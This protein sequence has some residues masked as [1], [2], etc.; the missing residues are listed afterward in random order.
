MAEA[1]VRRG[2]TVTMVDGSPQPMGTL[3]PDLGAKVGEAI[4]RFGV[5]LRCGEPVEAFEP[6]KVITS[7]GSFDADLVVLGLG[8]GI[9]VFLSRSAGPPDRERRRRRDDDDFDDDRPPRA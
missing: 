6:G 4:G 7:A 9:A 1:F 2:A 5:R 8:A 3:D